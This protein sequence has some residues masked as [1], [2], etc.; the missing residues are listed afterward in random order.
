MP[1]KERK[2]IGQIIH[3]SWNYDIEASLRV[4]QMLMRRAMN[5]QWRLTGTRITIGPYETLCGRS[6]TGSS[7]T[8]EPSGQLQL[9]LGLESLKK[10][11]PRSIG[12][13]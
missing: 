5:S 12:Q 7:M 13:Y 2:T 8:Q 6:G 3:P 9:L 1:K 10:W 4:H 11:L